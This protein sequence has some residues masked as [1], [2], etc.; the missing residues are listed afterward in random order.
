MKI[1][2]KKDM[3][4]VTKKGEKKNLCEAC[5]HN[6]KECWTLTE[7]FTEEE[8]YLTEKGKF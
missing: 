1:K 8:F 4:V 6:S 7:C 2:I 3:I 5:E